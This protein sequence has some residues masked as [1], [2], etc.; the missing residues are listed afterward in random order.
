MKKLLAILILSMSLIGIVNAQKYFDRGTGFFISDSLYQD[1]A[2][3]TTSDSTD[4][5]DE[6]SLNFDYDWLTI[7]ALDT[8]TTYTDSCIVEYAMYSVGY[9]TVYRPTTTYIVTGT[10]WQPVQFMRDSSWTNTNGYFLIDNS[11]IKSYK[12][13][14]G[15]YEKIRIRML[16]STIVA[17]RVWKYWIQASRKK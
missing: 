8:G 12:L 6:I 10:I 4:A 15:D 5:S 9:D 13:F 17:G 14:V 3:I 11:S 7:T 2:G 1:Y 16:N